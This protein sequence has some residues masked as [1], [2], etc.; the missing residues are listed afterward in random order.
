VP[1]DDPCSSCDAVVL[2]LEF[3]GCV[4]WRWALLDLIAA[5]LRCAG[6]KRAFFACEGVCR[7]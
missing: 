3:G 2:A 4:A 6:I 1:V 5:A 7:A